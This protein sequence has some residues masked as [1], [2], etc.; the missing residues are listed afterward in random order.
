MKIDVL[1][2][3]ADHPIRPHLEKWVQAQSKQHDV[4]LISKVS[5]MRGGHILF[6][7]SCTELIQKKHRDLYQKA[8]VIHA[9]DLPDGKGWSPHVWQILEGTSQIVVT[10]F[11]AVDAVDAGDIW[12]KET[13]SL[14]GHELYDEINEKLF[15]TELVLMDWAVDNFSTVKPQPQPSGKFRTY[16]KRNPQNSELD[17]QQSIASQFNL[18]RVCDPQRFPAY[19]IHQGQKYTITVKKAEG[20]GG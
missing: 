5:Q 17:A 18:L 19:F 7:I 9:S 13:F 10:L 14:Q 6:L 11:E 15:E 16:P 1:N 20:A 3:S 12:K 4:Q 2:S 8:L